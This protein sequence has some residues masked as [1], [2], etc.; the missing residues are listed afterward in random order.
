M[1]SLRVPVSR[2]AL[3]NVKTHTKAL[4]QLH[5]C[6]TMQNLSMFNP[7]VQQWT[8][9]MNQFEVNIHQKQ[10][11][12]LKTFPRGVFCY[13]VTWGSC[14]CGLF[15]LF[16]CNPHSQTVLLFYTLC[17]TGVSILSKQIEATATKVKV[18]IL[19]FCSKTTQITQT[20]VFN[21]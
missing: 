20:S 18:T 7:F 16:S 3:P 15:C 17:T 19:V 10:I 12:S 4:A 2:G 5:I 1:T 11:T 6:I 8:P 14:Y 9:V 13:H 21:Y